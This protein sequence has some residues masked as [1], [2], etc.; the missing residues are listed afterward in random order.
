MCGNLTV[1]EYDCSK[2]KDIIQHILRF[3]YETYKKS[4]LV[5]LILLKYFIQEINSWKNRDFLLL[6]EEKVLIKFHSLFN[7]IIKSVKELTKYGINPFIS[8]L[9]I[10]CVQLN[11]VSF[12]QMLF[13]E[14][15]MKAKFAFLP[16]N[17]LVCFGSIFILQN[18]IIDS[19]QVIFTGVEIRKYY[20]PERN[21]ED[22]DFSQCGRCQ[23]LKKGGK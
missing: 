4:K 1:N 7:I 2:S 22:L 21:F 11:Y 3:I 20:L 14:E 23:I 15:I 5:K 9:I 16:Q 10:G 18:T 17:F 12:H 8:C 13:E 19:F 6:K